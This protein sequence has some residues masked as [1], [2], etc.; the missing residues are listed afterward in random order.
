MITQ[1]EIERGGGSGGL[2]ARGAADHVG[3]D[4]VH[5]PVEPLLHALAKGT[6]NSR[7]PSFAVLRIL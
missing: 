6:R 2:H 5:E 4:A 3:P 7:S 1:R